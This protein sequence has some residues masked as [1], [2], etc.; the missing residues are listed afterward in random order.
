MNAR[1]HGRVAAT[2]TLLSGRAHRVGHKQR[3]MI[4]QQSSPHHATVEATGRGSASAPPDLAMLR[5]GVVTL[6]QDPKQ[7]TSESAQAIAKVLA[8][9]KGLKVP[10]SAIQTSGL[11]LQPT[12]EWEEASKKNVLVGYR[13]EHTVTVRTEVDRAGEVYDA[14]VAAGANE[15]GGIQLTLADDSLLRREALQKATKAAVAEIHAVGEALGVVLV[16]PIQAQVL[17][18]DAARPLEVMMR[19]ADVSTTPVAAGLVEVVTQ[20]RV[21]FEIK[22]P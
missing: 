9:L 8:A 22:H 1:S 15:A 19:A 11:S 17:A 12:Y 20:V 14:G 13:A 10:E 3:T 18:G 7:A 5:L 16:G 6:S 2:E 21:V 4:T